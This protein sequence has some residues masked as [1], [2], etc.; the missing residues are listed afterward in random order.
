MP[1]MCI[2]IQLQQEKSKLGLHSFLHMCGTVITTY[3]HRLATAC[4]FL[5]LK[6]LFLVLQGY[7]C[8]VPSPGLGLPG[9]F[10]LSL[11]AT[12]SMSPFSPQEA[13]LP[14]L[15]ASQDSV[16]GSQLPSCR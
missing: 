9:T 4:G 11:T 10:G 12:S 13:L 14:S 8:S 2:N 1:H 15:P 6:A 7:H 3:S 16:R 5:L